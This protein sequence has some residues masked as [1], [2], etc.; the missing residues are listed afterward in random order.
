MPVLETNQIIRFESHVAVKD[1]SNGSPVLDLSLRYWISLISRGLG[2]WISFK[3]SDLE[4]SEHF[5]SH[6]IGS[7]GSHIYLLVN[8]SFSRDLK[9]LTFGFKDQSFIYY[10]I[11]SNLFIRI[12]ELKIYIL[13]ALPLRSHQLKST[14]QK[15]LIQNEKH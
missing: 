12:Y 15:F 13:L 1:L 8:V 5:K 14:S 10:F 11:T 2:P 3:V 9:T 6:G 4:F 7:L